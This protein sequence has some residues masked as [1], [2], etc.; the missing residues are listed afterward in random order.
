M[1]RFTSNARSNPYYFSGIETDAISMKLD[2][3]AIK[4]E[5]SLFRDKGDTDDER[6]FVSVGDWTHWNYADFNTRKT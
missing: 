4:I 6:L 1:K 2:L 5:T 3:D